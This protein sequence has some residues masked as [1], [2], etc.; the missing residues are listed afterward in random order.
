[1]GSPIWLLARA[2]SS[3]RSILETLQGE[4]G[5]F[6]DDQVPPIGTSEGGLHPV[7]LLL[8]PQSGHRSPGIKCTHGLEVRVLE[9]V[10]LH[11]KP[12]RGN[13]DVVTKQGPLGAN[14]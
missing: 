5:G 3:F 2:M 10:V 4:L 13:P 9:A 8:L 6:V 7:A 1:M 14:G 11:Q 12:D